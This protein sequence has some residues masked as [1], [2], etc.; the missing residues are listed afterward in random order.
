VVIA[1]VAR[2][3]IRGCVDIALSWLAERR[4]GTVHL[5]IDGDELTVTGLDMLRSGQS[6]IGDFIKRHEQESRDGGSAS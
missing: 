2:P 4:N 5:V 1:M 6:T 3:L